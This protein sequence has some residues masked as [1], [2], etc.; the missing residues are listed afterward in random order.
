VNVFGYS[1]QA[2]AHA[3]SGLLASFGGELY[4][5]RIDST[6]TVFNPVTG[7]LTRPRPLFPDNA[8]YQNTGAFSQ[9]SYRFSPSLSIAGGLRVTGV[10]FATVA[11]DVLR[12]PESSQWFHDVTFQSS[13]QWRVAGPFSVHGLVSRGFRAPNLNDLGALGLND[14]GYEIPASE[15]IPAGA[16]LSTDAGEAALS[17]GVALA[18]LK[19]ESLMNYEFGMK[20]RTRRIYARAQ[21]FDS[22]LYDPIVRRTLLFPAANAPATLAGLPVTP[23]AQTAAQ[24]AAGVVAVATAID[25]RAVK[26]FVNDGQ[27]RYY[28]L[29]TMGRVSLTNRFDLEGNYSYIVGRDLFPNRNIRRLPPQ[30]GAISARYTPSGRRPW[31]QVTVTAAGEQSRLSGGDRDDERIGASFRRSDIAAFFRGSRV[32]AQTVNGVFKPTGETLAQ[33]QDRVLPLGATIN[34]VRVVDDNTRV[35]MYTATAGWAAVAVR[36][37]MPIGERWQLNLS[38]ENLLDRNYRFHGSGI[39]APGFHA[40]VGVRFLF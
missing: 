11:N 37:G 3:G 35:L 25:P 38:I 21:L 1:A 30:M 27:S 23:I 28:G 40:W 26:A 2:T 8:R 10:R 31:L 9:A 22:E 15:A 33:I 29:E 32:A 20:V 16:L 17:K 18:A 5:E 4:D 13:V 7:A 6:R 34:G 24:R 12:I 19:P 14:L 36:S 39:D